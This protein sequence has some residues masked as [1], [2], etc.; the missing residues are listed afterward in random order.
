MAVSI[1]T[2][3]DDVEWDTG[4]AVAWVALRWL[5]DADDRL[6]LNVNAPNV[7]HAELRGFQRTGLAAFGAVQTVVTEA[8]EGYVKLAYEGIDAEA[9]TG[10]G[11][12]RPGR[13]HGLVHRVACSV[14]G[15]RQRPSRTTRAGLTTPRAGLSHPFRILASMSEID[16]SMQER[17]DRWV[18]TMDGAQHNGLC[19]AHRDYAAAAGPI[20]RTALRISS[21]GSCADGAPCGRRR[22]RARPEEPDEWRTCFERDRDRILHAPLPPAGGQDPG[23]RFSRRPPAHPVHARPRGRPGRHGNGP[24]LGLNVPSPRRSPSA[25]TAATVRAATPARTPSAVVPGGYD[26]AVWG[27]DVLAPTEPVRRD[28]RRDP[29]PLVGPARRSPPRGRSS[30]G[31]I[32]SPTSAT[33]SRMPWR[34]ASSA[35]TC[36]RPSCERC[37]RHTS[38]F[39]L[40]HRGVVVPLRGPAGWG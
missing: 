16:T 38:Q 2:S 37:G 6:V 14:R 34:R 7:P 13:R 31:P 26:H 20:I 40:V 36:C 27:A 10:H 23:L 29:Q 3:T 28:S 8:G 12:R 39:A 11:C 21:A 22:A 35:P 33:T 19:L 9:R 18:A 1:D 25:T 30:R 32:A 4:A 17:A 5:L 24:Q 15:V